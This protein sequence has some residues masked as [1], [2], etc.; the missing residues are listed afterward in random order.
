MLSGTEYVNN[1]VIPRLFET[2]PTSE[3]VQAMIKAWGIILTHIEEKLAI[4]T[5]AYTITT[6]PALPIASAT[7]MTVSITSGKGLKNTGGELAQKFVQQ[8]LGG[9]QTPPETIQNL[10]NNFNNLFEHITTKMDIIISN[11]EHK[12]IVYTSTPFTYGGKS[13]VP[14][15]GAGI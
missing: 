1:Y 11:I 12:G 6:L 2:V 8:M 10:T 15:K 4:Q 14:I 9:R 5:I 13:S 7:P 3:Q